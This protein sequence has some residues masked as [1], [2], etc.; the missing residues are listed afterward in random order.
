MTE[1]A[2]T[3]IKLLQSMIRN[4]CVN[5]FWSRIIQGMDAHPPPDRRRAS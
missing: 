1:V 4:A 2:G 3:T 5:D